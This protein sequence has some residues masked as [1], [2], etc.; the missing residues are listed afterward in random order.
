[1]SQV[2]TQVKVTKE[3]IGRTYDLPLPELIFK[4]QEIHRQYFNPNE[5]Q[6]C[7]LSS[8]KTGAC[9]EDC[10][11]CSQSARYD[12]DLKVEPLLDSNEILKEAAAAK[13]N[14][15]TR[16]CMGAAWRSAPEDQQ[17]DQVVELVSKVKE[18]GMEPCVTLGMLNKEQAL[19]LK[20]AGLHSYNHN[21]D[22]SPEYYSQ[23]IS[24]RKFEDR[25]ETIQNVQAA[26][27]NVCSGGILGLGESK[28]DRL[29]FLTELANLDPYPSS[30]PIN[31]LVPIKGTPQYKRL[32]EKHKS[33]I[34]EAGIEDEDNIAKFMSTKMRDIEFLIDKIEL[35]RCIATA[36]IFMPKARVR[37]SAGRLSM[38]D[39]L[40]ALCF[41]AGANSIHTGAKLLTTANPG[42]SHD[43]NLIDK[44]GMTILN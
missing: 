17:F 3:D 12:T 11:Y 6:F 34:E 44:L 33:L 23:I 26:G 37:L 30:V 20:E 5:V 10:N 8:I 31:V 21:I 27:I 32:E 28:D 29:S 1:M 38:S 43:H 14:G 2:A 16:F 22:T 13:A 9:P 40:Q 7:T 15:S 41:I 4:A 36:R 18:M 24:T 35:I 19:R 42:D 25:I 39:E